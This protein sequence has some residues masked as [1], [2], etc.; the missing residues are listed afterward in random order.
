[1]Q[2][3]LKL[4][5]SIPLI[6][7]AYIMATIVTQNT[8]KDIDEARGEEV[9]SNYKSGI[10]TK[11]LVIWDNK[12]YDKSNDKVKG[13]FNKQM[14]WLNRK[15]NPYRLNIISYYLLKLPGVICLFLFIVSD[16]VLWAKIA[17]FILSIIC[18]F[19]VEIKYIDNDKDDKLE[20]R[21]DLFK[22]YNQLD[23][24]SYGEITTFDSLK[25]SIG[26]IKNKRFRKAY[27]EMIANTLEHKNLPQAL[28]ELSDQF[29]MNEIDSFIT[30]IIQGEETGKTRDMISSQRN[31]IN[32]RYLGA[33]DI[34]TEQ[35]Q[36]KVAYGLILLVVSILGIVM[37]SFVIMIIEKLSG[38][39]F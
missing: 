8:N 25:E 34:E 20:I 7:I 16:V 30:T 36:S 15:G 27:T 6:I 2:L 14:N 28:T 18:L 35:K 12:L 9:K 10:L 33:K 26:I 23:V 21:K 13:I 3:I 4:I 22:I 37:Y 38:S 24:M 29:D 32:K 19:Y 39:L 1:M 31:I 5:P 17:L 11:Q